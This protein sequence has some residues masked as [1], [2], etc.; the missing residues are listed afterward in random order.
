LFRNA[1]RV[2]ILVEN[3][4]QGTSFPLQKAD[5]DLFFAGERLNFDLFVK[6]LET[7]VRMLCLVES[8]EVGFVQIFLLSIRYF[9]V[10]KFTTTTITPLSLLISCNLSFPIVALKASS[11]P[12]FELNSPN[13]ILMWYFR[14]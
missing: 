10:A 14:N 3:Y 13:N 6:L 2:D 7:S 8:R 11:L 1:A 4:G 12:A 9:D 5:K